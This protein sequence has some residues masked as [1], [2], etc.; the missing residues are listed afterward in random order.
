MNDHASLE[1]ITQANLAETLARILPKAELLRSGNA[2]SHTVPALETFHVALPKGP[3]VKEIQVDLE[4][5]LPAPRA[6]VCTA[7]LADAES[8]L[9]YV[10]RH[11]DPACSLVWCKFDPRTFEL[12]FTLVVDEHAKAAPGWRRH[13]ASYTPAASAEWITWTKHNGTAGAKEQVEFAEFLE[14]N[15]GDIASGE[16]L[17][18]SADMMTMATNFE[19]TSEKRLRSSVRLS[20]GAIQLEYI[21]KEDEQTV[22]RMRLFDKFSIGIPVFWAGPGYRIDARLKHRIAQGKARFWYELIR[23][24]RVHEAA[25]KDLIERVRAGI[26]GVPMLMGAC[27]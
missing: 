17:P 24:D 21:D 20:S 27:K 2:P 25:A 6:T 12:A 18:T 13:Q 16:G 8:F 11:A 9:G 15:E 4:K 7:T 23:P 5:Y 10:T 1:S 14:R 3:E 22:E 26:G 19:V